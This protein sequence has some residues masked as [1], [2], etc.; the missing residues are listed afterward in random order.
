MTAAATART[1]PTGLM[2][3][4]ALLPK[5][6]KQMPAMARRKPV[7]KRFPGLDPPRNRQLRIAVKKGAMLMMTPTLDASVKV[8]AIFSRR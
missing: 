4:A 8:R 5:L 3:R 2:D 1:S 6:M 7:K